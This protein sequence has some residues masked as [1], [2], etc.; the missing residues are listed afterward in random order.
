MEETIDGIVN[1]LHSYTSAGLVKCPSCGEKSELLGVTG[2]SDI[3]YQENSTAVIA[4][5][6]APC[7]SVF[8]ELVIFPQV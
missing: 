3:G 2:E 5:F 4:T 1:K 7:G 6:S 8:S